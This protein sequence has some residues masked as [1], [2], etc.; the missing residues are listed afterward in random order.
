M[1]VSVSRRTDIPAFYSD[2]FFNRVKAG[3]VDVINPFNAKQANRISLDKDNV[4]C[5]VFWTKNPKPMLNKLDLLDGFNYYFQFTLNSYGKDLE[6]N[7]PIKSKE[8]IDTF[9]NLSKMIG[10]EKVIWRYD[11]IILT[12]KYTIDYH[13]KYFE[14]L[15]EKLHNYTEKCVISFLDLYKK[16]ERNLKNIILDELTADKMDYIAC[17]FSR[18]CKK[19]NL[20][21]ATCCEQIELSKYDIIHNKCIDDELIE[22]I[23]GKKLLNKKR[24]GQ[25]EA[26]GCIKCNDIGAY[27]TCLHNCKYCYASYS[28]DLIKVNVQHHDK[29]SSVL[30]GTLSENIKIYEVK[31]GNEN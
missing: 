21:L 22:R 26:C 2:W 14:L 10:K 3:F 31:H 6:P 13:I 11:P 28:S 15:A 27:N 8:L 29:L 4:E 30:V 24:D 25:R 19:Y 12:D 1:I 16:T 5:F 7:V 17:E 9:I 23:S 20:K 18:I